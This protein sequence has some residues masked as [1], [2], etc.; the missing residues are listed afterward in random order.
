[1]RR[2][3]PPIVLPVLL[4]LVGLAAPSRVTG[5]QVAGGGLDPAD[6]PSPQAVASWQ[7]RDLQPAAESTL[8]DWDVLVWDFAEI[9]GVV[10]VGGRFTTVRKYSGAPEHDQPFLAAFDRDSGTWISTFR[11][12]LDDGVYALA[13]T[14]D[15]SRL[16]VGGEFSNVDGAPLTS[17]LAA[18][19]PRTGEPDPGWTASFT[20]EDE[21][22]VVHD[23]EVDPVTG[24]VYVAGRF[25]HVESSVPNS[26]TRRY[27]L[28]RL[29]GGD[30]SLDRTWDVKV[31]GGRV[32]A[33]ALDPG[34]GRLHV[35]G[36]FG[37]I[38]Q[39]PDTKWAGIVDTTD[40][41]V[42]ALATPLD[43]ERQRWVFDVAVTDDLVLFATEAHWLYLYD[44]DGELVRRYHSL[45]HGGDPQAL[46]NDG[47]ALWVGGHFHGY[48]YDPSAPA[49]DFEL[50]QWL[51]P[52][53]PATGRPV[54]GW[55][56]RLGMTDGVW[57]LFR[58][59][60]GNLWVGGDPTSVG[61]QPVSGFAVLP[62]QPTG[63]ETNL[64]VGGLAIQSSTGDSNL[65]GHKG[66]SE[67]R[68]D[69]LGRD[70][71]GPAGQ[72]VDG[73]I[74]GGIYECSIAVT[75][76][77]T[78]PWWQV[79][80]GAVGEVDT[81]RI[82]NVNGTSR[83]QE[84]ADVHV[85]VSEDPTAIDTTDLAA[86]AAD[87]AVTLVRFDGPLPWYDE[88]PVGA[89][90]R[91][92]R[93]LMDSPE[94]V[95]LRLAE[96]EV[97][98]HRDLVPPPRAEPGTVLVEAGGLWRYDDL[99]GEGPDGWTDL[100]F[101]DAAWSTGSAPLGFGDD[102]LVTTTRDRV[103]ATR[104]RTTFDS[105]P[106]ARANGLTVDLMVDDGAV[107]WLNGVEIGR[108]RMPLG[109]ATADTEAAGT[110]WGAEERAWT[111]L[112]VPPSLVTDG[113]NVLT[114]QVH[115]N[116]IGGS[117]IRFD[118][119]VVAADEPV[120]DGPRDELL[121][122]L[123]ADWRYLDTGV[124]P[125]P[126]WTGAGFDDGAWS[127]GPAQLGYGDGD[128]AT[129]VDEGPAGARHITTWFRRTFEVDDPAVFASLVLDLVRDDGAVVHLNGVE[130]VRSNLPDGPIGSDT[131]ARDYAWGPGET[132]PQR[133][134][135]PA[136]A[137]VAG[138]NVV[139]VEVHSA[140]RGSSDLSFDLRL[141]GRVP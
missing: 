70:L 86:L 18:L 132:E 66:T 135:V 62:A 40:G 27:S 67:D 63:E 34:R 21:D 136:D 5:A 52:L 78:T 103:L 28:A 68:C 58:D 20:D 46:L 109:A 7:V 119:R 141:E 1:M 49:T 23:I 81:V 30:G 92:V 94:P 110:V 24:A 54:S 113:E 53:D 140:D 84:L 102:D 69:V 83:A 128:E 105:T 12:S 99:G 50:V 123:G 36:F 127:T 11:P 22:V 48:H 75:A 8:P 131:L 130:L 3:S 25:S 137:L 2:W 112:A 91:Y 29:D 65:S 80:L 55:T 45:G 33:L 98:D 88:I 120:A 57:A 39:V 10:Y 60:A 76:A 32:M 134:E 59:S 61:T 121:V 44:H 42:S 125:G 106:T 108:I 19:D 122:D 15:G 89:H 14:A 133:F 114:V 107:A 56:G 87:P 95:Q 47:Q 72:A 35:G 77:E 126:G 38:D 115:N 71:I 129:V 118:A 13:A 26:R 82:W 9:D 74:G 93:V 139:A 117:D 90:G 104:F 41:T 111:S 100:G 64:A 37:T 96:V 6:L 17:G 124:D 116:W 101:D 43:P 4:V 79:D 138:T 31:G 85:A 73:K 97:I 51:L 16:L